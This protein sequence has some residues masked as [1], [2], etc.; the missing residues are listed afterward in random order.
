MN[1]LMNNP[2]GFCGLATELCTDRAIDKL[3]FTL[4]VQAFY[5]RLGRQ[6]LDWDSGATTDGLLYSTGLYHAVLC[7]R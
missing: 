1:Q 3:A 2:A 6:K 7:F 4:C 5:R